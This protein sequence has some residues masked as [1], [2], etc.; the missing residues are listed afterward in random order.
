MSGKVTLVGAGPGDPGLLTLK[1]AEAIKSADVVLYDRLVGPK[2]L[3]L[4]PEE[5]KRIDVGKSSG[6]HRVSQDEINRL[7]LDYALDGKQVVRL[8]GGDSFVFGRGGEE[9]ELLYKNG[10]PFEVVPGITSAVAVPAY[11][12]IPVTHR[13]TSSSLH[14]VTAHTKDG[15][16]PEIDFK[17]YAD[18]GGTLVFLMGASLLEHIV[19]GLI[20]GG[21]DIYTPCAVIE[22]GTTPKQR[23]TLGT[24]NDIEEKAGSIESPAVIIVGGVCELS[25]KFDWY[26]KLPLHGRTI[27][28][29]RHENASSGLSAILCGLGAD[30]IECP[31][32][33]TESLVDHKTAERIERELKACDTA[34]FTSANG[35]RSVMEGLKKYG[36][37]AR[38]FGGVKIGAVGGATAA[39]LSEYGMIA[40]IIPGEY[41]GKALGAAIADSG[42]GSVLLLR[43]GN[44]NGDIDGILRKAGIDCKEI[45]VYNTA[46]ECEFNMT[47]LI[48]EGKID[49]V[50]FTSGSTVK[51]F[52]QFH[53]NAELSAFKAVCIGEA[54][55]KETADCGMKCIV[56]PRASLEAMAEVIAADTAMAK[57]VHHNYEHI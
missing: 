6:S 20:G 40:D 12:G 9:L 32:I 23:K 7:L 19:K 22:H 10:V 5:A 14:I 18:I 1:G 25:E 51:G 46:A 28:V 53:K 34:A 57:G 45:C 31:C 26:S 41:S 16:N 29:T 36:R 2:I 8:K 44:A 50:T 39:A 49:Y 47:E 24:L 54:T 4:I 13:G 43:A 38:V 48:N 21:M 3:E 37:D 11:A 30:V 56:A 17:T 52:M 33:H 27:A 35:V 42:A 55:A 15:A